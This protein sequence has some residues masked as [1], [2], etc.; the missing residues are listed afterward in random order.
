MKILE[1]KLPNIKVPDSLKEIVEK[2]V[3][4]AA[5]AAATA[6]LAIVTE[7]LNKNGKSIPNKRKG[8]SKKISSRK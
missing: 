2:I 1:I 5:K 6:A 4:E 8:G 7:I 3:V